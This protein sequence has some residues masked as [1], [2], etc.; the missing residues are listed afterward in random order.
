MP[1]GPN[2]GVARCP[3]P[4]I[5]PLAC[6]SP[7]LPVL[8]EPRSEGCHT[9]AP[10]PPPWPYLI[11]VLALS[12]GLMALGFILIPTAREEPLPSP[13]PNPKALLGAFRKSVEP[14]EK[15]LVQEASREGPPWRCMATIL[16]SQCRG[17]EF[18][19]CSGKLDPITKTWHSQTNKHIFL[20]KP[21]G[22]LDLEGVKGQTQ[23][24]SRSAQVSAG[25]T[26][27][28]HSEWPSATLSP[29]E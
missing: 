23:V 26:R 14:Q 15:R 9:P 10:C 8:S 29:N 5:C 18:D 4:S 11:P 1:G 16:C 24:K 27:S 3:P 6:R 25:H 22:R 20:N 7:R 12:V 19:P 21:Q 17:P 28:V 2:W 13:M